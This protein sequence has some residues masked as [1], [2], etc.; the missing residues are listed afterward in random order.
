MAEAEHAGIKLA[1]LYR[2]KGQLG[3][4]SDKSI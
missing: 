3:V 2:A 1:T 4:E